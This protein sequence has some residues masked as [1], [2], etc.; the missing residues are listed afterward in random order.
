MKSVQYAYQ[1]VSKGY[2]TDV[3]TY[4]T[5][6]EARVALKA[7][8]EAGCDAFIVQHVYKL[9]DSRRVR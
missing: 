3:S 8:K 6:K 5:R 7:E 2:D 1:V 4:P 9:E